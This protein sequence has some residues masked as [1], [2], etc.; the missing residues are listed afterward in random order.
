L[1]FFLIGYL[2]KYLS[3]YAKNEKIW[4]IINL[5]IIIFM[6]LLSIFVIL[7]TIN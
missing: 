2:S 3:S 7:E 4:K 1:F 6:S 5:F